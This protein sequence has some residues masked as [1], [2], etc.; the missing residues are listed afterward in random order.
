MFDSVQELSAK[1]AASGYFI[2][3]VMT[4]DIF[5][6]AKL[7]KPVILEGPAGSGKFGTCCPLRAAKT[8]SPLPALIASSASTSCSVTL[9]NRACCSP[10]CA[11]QTPNRNLTCT[12][13]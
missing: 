5:L 2:D 8:N 4:M 7:R 12:S 1:L 10:S 6:A 3:S 13:H 9:T 11:Q